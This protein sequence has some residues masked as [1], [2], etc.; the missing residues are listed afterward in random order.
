MSTFT[1]KGSE[2]DVESIMA[3]IRKRVEEKRKGMYTEEEKGPRCG[4]GRTLGRLGAGR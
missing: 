3:N 2:I 4:G 1:I